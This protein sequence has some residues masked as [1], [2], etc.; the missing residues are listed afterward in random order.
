MPDFLLSPKQQAVLTWLKDK[1]TEE[2]FYG[3]GAGSAKSFLG[4]YWHVKRRLMYPKTRGVIGRKKINVLKQSTMVTLWKV[5]GML[6]LKPGVHYR[7]NDNKSTI[8]W[9]NGSETIM[10]ELFY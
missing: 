8:K 9:Y 3:G 1:E 4:C 6:G 7:Y 10:L 5:M 2:V